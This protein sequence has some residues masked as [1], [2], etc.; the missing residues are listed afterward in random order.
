MR[1]GSDQVQGSV[2]CTDHGHR[3]GCHGRPIPSGQV[4]RITE[5]LEGLDD[6]GPGGCSVGFEVDEQVQGLAG[7]RVKDAIAC[8]TGHETCDGVFALEDIEDG[9]NVEGREGA[10][11]GQGGQLMTN[12]ERSVD[13]GDV[14]FDGNGTDGQGRVERNITPVVV[15]RMDGFLERE[16][17]VREAV[18][19]LQAGVMSRRQRQ[20]SADLRG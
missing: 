20:R 8:R 10:G 7:G 11:F 15:V 1:Q 6:G 16:R 17:L 12:I 9:V 13:E 19:D 2:P 14:G 5:R 3:P 18:M 4:F